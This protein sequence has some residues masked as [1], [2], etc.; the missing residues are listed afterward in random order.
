MSVLFS[1]IRDFT[2]LSE[3]MTP[4]ENFK[5][6]NYYLSLMEPLNLQIQRFIDKYIADAIMALFSEGAD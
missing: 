4:P 3:Q 2:T 1:D 6:I 5:F